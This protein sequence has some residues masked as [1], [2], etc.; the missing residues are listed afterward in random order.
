VVPSETIL[1]QLKYRVNSCTATWLGEQ[2]MPQKL[3]FLVF[4]R[5]IEGHTHFQVKP[6]T[7]LGRHGLGGEYVLR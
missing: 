7:L 1:W 2:E 6:L 5:L 4:E 3:K